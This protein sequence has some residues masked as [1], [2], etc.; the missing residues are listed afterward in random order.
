MHAGSRTRFALVTRLHWGWFCC[1]LLCAA[2][3]V[4]GQASQVGQLML[5][6]AGCYTAT[7][8]FFS[9][10]SGLQVWYELVG[11][12]PSRHSTACPHAHSA[13]TPLAAT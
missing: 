8:L 12:G 3:F 13:T 2:V 4:D 10:K 11:L 7:A 6:S 1:Y 9:F 5:W